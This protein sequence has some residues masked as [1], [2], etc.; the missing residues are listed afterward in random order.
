MI[1]LW[2][3][4]RRSIIHGWPQSQRQFSHFSLYPVRRMSAGIYKCGNEILWLNNGRARC[5]Q[6]AAIRRHITR[7]VTTFSAVWGQTALPTRRDSPPHHVPRDQM[8]IWFGT[9]LTLIMRHKI[10]ENTV[11]TDIQDYGA[12]EILSYHQN[13]NSSQNAQIHKRNY[14]SS[15]GLTPDFRAKRRLHADSV[16]C[17]RNL[18]VP[19]GTKSTLPISLRGRSSK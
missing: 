18:T 12:D 13:Y 11:R 4:N 2:H 17:S 19:S 5:P 16:R 3:I 9:I 14:N 8:R 6:R 10:N 7:R 15:W 1:L